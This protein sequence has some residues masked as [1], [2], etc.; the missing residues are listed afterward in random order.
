MYRAVRSILALAL[1]VIFAIA[2]PGCGTA[3]PTLGVAPS[4]YI[5]AKALQKQVSQTQ[6]ELAQ[7]LQS[8]PSEFAITQ[9]ALEQLEPLYLGDLPAYRIQGT[10]HLTIKLPKQ[11][12][13]ETINSFNIYLQRQKEGKTWR[14]ALPQYI[15][16]HILNNWRTYL[17]E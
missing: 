9:I 8:P 10:Y 1:T 4:K 2:L 13:T 3:K 15:N 5:I 6:Q 12:L 7:Q 17:L 14:V 16:K 11:P